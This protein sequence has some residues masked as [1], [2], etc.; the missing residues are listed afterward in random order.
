DFDLFIPDQRG[1]QSPGAQPLSYFFRGLVA[2]DSRHLFL[3]VL[4]GHGT[5]LGIDFDRDGIVNGDESARQRWLRDRDGD[6]F[7]DGYERDHGG[8]EDDPAAGPLDATPPRLRQDPVTGLDAF[9]L[10]MARASHAEF[11]FHATE[12]VRWELEATSLV[13]PLGSVPTVRS[14]GASFARAHTIHLHGLRASEVSGELSSYRVRLKL[15]DRA[16]LSNTYELGSSI[17]TSV[18]RGSP[19]NAS[20]DELR[21]VVNDISVTGESYVAAAQTLQMILHVEVGSLREILRPGVPG[22]A[23][24]V[25]PLRRGASQES[26]RRFEP[27]QIAHTGPNALNLS[28]PTLF[29]GAPYPAAPTGPFIVVGETNDSGVVSAQVTLSGVGPDEQIAISIVALPPAEHNAGPSLAE[30]SFPVLSFS[31]WVMPA[32]DPGLRLK[33]VR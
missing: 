6:G 13:G 18:D 27:A 11:A 31:D 12:E 33:R 32:T 30:P 3:G 19:I 8:T 15:T 4:A 29:E 5:R 14:S 28:L 9:E 2:Q 22:R 20:G 21:V 10:L 23:V 24:I 7:P 26:W 25:Q 16:G 17:A 1:D